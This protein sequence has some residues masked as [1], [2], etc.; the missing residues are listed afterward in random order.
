[1]LYLDPNIDLVS[2]ALIELTTRLEK[3]VGSALISLLDI[4]VLAQLFKASSPRLSTVTAS[5]SSMYLHA[6]LAAILYPI[7][8]LVG[9]TFILMSSLARFSNSAARITTEVVPSP[10]YASCNCANWTK[11][12]AVG[13]STSSFFKIVAPE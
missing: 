6:S 5:L 10:T 1:M 7:M 8:M 3:N 13:C 11:R 4:E 2:I 12:F 9:C